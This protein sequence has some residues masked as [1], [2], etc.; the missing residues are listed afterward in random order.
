MCNVC[1]VCNV[2]TCMSKHYCT[3]CN[4][5]SARCLAAF[6]AA[7]AYSDIAAVCCDSRIVRWQEI[8]SPFDWPPWLPRSTAALAMASIR[9]PRGLYYALFSFRNFPEKHRQFPMKI[10]SSNAKQ[11]AMRS[12]EQSE[13]LQALQTLHI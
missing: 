6:S 1:N 9:H 3:V 10:D 8:L 12:S 13:A 4:A 7:L 5:R 11:R 2:L